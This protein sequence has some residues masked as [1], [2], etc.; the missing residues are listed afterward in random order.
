MARPLKYPFDTSLPFQVIRG[1]GD[2]PGKARKFA[3]RH[4]LAVT[5]E[6]Q[7]EPG[8]VRLQAGGNLYRVEF[9]Q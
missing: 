6:L 2:L 8:E 5:V 9:R 7:D 4:G 1:G 3:L